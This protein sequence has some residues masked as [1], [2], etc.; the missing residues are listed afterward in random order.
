MSETN[1]IKIFISHSSADSLIGEK[2]LDAL[3]DLG[4]DEKSIFY[5][6]KYHTGVKLGN[7]FHKVVKDALKNSHIVIFLL[8]RNFYKSAACL[9]EMG[10][11]WIN[12]KNILPI[13]LDGLTFADMKG[14]IDSHYI[15]Y[16]PNRDDAYKLKS[17]LK[18]FIGTTL[19]DKDAKEIFES[20]IKEANEMAKNMLIQG[21]EYIEYSQIE[22]MI[23]NGK[24]TEDELLLINYIYEKQLDHIYD[25]KGFDYETKKSF[26]TPEYNDIVSYSNLFVDFNIERAKNSLRRSKIIEY[27]YVQGMGFESDYNG[28]IV[29]IN[30]FRDI[31]SM[32]DECKN[33]LEKTKIKNLKAKDSIDGLTSKNL[34]ED[35]ILGDDFKEI[36]GLFYCFVKDTYTNS[37]GDRWMADKTI[38]EIRRW[39]HQNNLNNKLSTSYSDVLKILKHRNLLEIVETTSYGNPRLYRIKNEAEKQLHKLKESTNKVLT[40]IVNNN[41]YEDDLPF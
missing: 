16:E 36:E 12:D 10:A 40:N 2:F 33:L 15:A 11:C 31:I 39:E 1:E 41:K 27:E 18:P 8:T 32:R 14:F 22:K 28:F 13:L 35:I 5:S 37:F 24:F 21:E 17:A 29:D 26:E 38:K 19:K 7:D 25:F 3:I 9:N 4:I 6:S 23:L 30:C 20:F 34:I